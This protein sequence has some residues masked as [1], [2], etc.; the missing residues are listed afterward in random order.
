MSKSKQKSAR[1]I[2]RR[3]VLRGAGVTMALP[4]LPSLSAFADTVKP[5]VFPKRLAI[6]FMGTGINE[7][8]WSAEGSGADMK[9][10]KTLAVLEPIKQKINVIDGLFQKAAT[11]QGIHPAQT[12]ALLSGAHIQKG[13]IIHAGITFDQLIANTIGQDNPQASIVLAC[14]QPMTGYHETNFSLAYSSHISW[15][16]PDS[17]VPVEVYPSLAFDNLFENRGSLR[18]LSILDRVRDRAQALSTKISSTDK[19]KL[20]E[21]LTSV[22]EVEKRVDSMRKTKTVA[23]DA[24]K[25][26]NRPAFTMERPANGLPE[27]LRDHARLMCD[28][29][30][31]AFQTDRTRVASLLLARDLSAMY[32]PFLEVKDGH[33]AA[34]HDNLSDGYERIARFHLSQLAYLATKLDSMPEG[35]GTVL[36]NSCVMWLSNMWAGRKH[37]NFRLPLVLAGGLGGTL[38][39]GRTLNYVGQSEDKRKMCSLFLS[40]MDRMGVKQDRFGDADTR[41]ERI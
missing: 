8:H 16:T 30:A 5:E 37:D 2:T 33:H 25:G 20:D 15:Q 40:I 29:I 36:D 12:G 3:T 6:L 9:L 39:T 28:I 14:E 22:R 18:N 35:N 31:I 13:A 17:P 1:L 10:S 27:D 32:Y 24:A 34:S 23:D 41:L 26:K 19:T 7:N 11:G 21:Y 4:W 38:E